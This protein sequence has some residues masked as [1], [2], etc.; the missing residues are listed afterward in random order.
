MPKSSSNLASLGSLIRGE[1]KLALSETNEIVKETA[2]NVM[3]DVTDNT[4]VDTSKALS[5]WQASLTNPSS[6]EIEAHYK[7]EKGS[8]QGQ[9]QEVALLVANNAINQR[10]LGQAIYIYNPI[11]DGD[12]QDNAALLLAQQEAMDNAITAIAKAELRIRVS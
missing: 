7:G 4:I 9:S 12:Y 8:T 11:Q 5:N 6:N 3:R 2:R 10:E 1:L